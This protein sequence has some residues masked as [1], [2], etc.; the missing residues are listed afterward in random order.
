MKF[1]QTKQ[2]KLLSLA[3]VI[4]LVGAGAAVAISQSKSK[5]SA[6]SVKPLSIFPAPTGIIGGTSPTPSGE[7]FVLV[8]LNGKANIQLLSG[9]SKTPLATFPVSNAATGI[10]SNGTS[11]VGISQGTLNAGSV[12]FYTT[13]SHKLFNTVPLPGPAIGIQSGPNPSIFYALVQV[14]NNDSL[15]LVS[16]SSHKVQGSIPM[17]ADTT[18]FDISADGSTVYALQGNGTVSLIGVTTGKVQS[19]FSVG[20]GARSMALSQDNSRLYVLK[21][22]VVNDNVSVVDVAKSSVKYVLPAP[23][24][25]VQ[26]Q[27]APNN[28]ELYDIVGNPSYGN[29]QVF[30]TN[31]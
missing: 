9:T 31:A 6:S 1:L 19:S 29:I 27:V 30:P 16:P 23:A 2:Q 7:L 10:A 21:G 15:D 26:I 12:A 25:A 5:T 24:Y 8:N 28:T 3:V 22:S 18:A 4:V 20:G 17:P 14:N 11:T 13:G